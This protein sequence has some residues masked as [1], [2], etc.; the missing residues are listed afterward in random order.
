M[1]PNPGRCA[2]QRFLRSARIIAIL[3]TVDG[4]S[5]AVGGSWLATNLDDSR[6]PR[7]LR[8]AFVLLFP[9]WY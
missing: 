6:E 1:W 2:G 3:D 4:P 9:S 7:S 5:Q 8:F